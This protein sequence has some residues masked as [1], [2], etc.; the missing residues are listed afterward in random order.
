MYTCKTCGTNAK[1]P[2]HLCN[3]C[4]DKGRCTFCDQDD[5]DTRHMCGT[6]LA[7]LKFVCGECGRVATSPD[8]LC[9]PDKILEG[10]NAL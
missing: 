6:K 1:E 2:G 8:Q 7:G 10:E 5:V 9:K 4:Q 3:P